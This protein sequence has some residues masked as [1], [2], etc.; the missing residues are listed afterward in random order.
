M[1]VVVAIF[2]PL[3]LLCHAGTG[4]EGRAGTG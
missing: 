1:T 3:V 4:R 2:F